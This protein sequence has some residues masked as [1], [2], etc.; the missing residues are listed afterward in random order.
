MRVGIGRGLALTLGAVAQAASSF[1][2]QIVLMR[3]LLPEDFGRF[4]V[5]LAGCSLV[6]TILSWRL[7]VLILRLAPDDLTSPA[8]L[9]Y[10]AGL[11]WETVAAACCTLV[12]L[13]LSGLMSLYALVLVATL[14]L[15][16]WG[17]QNI[18]FYE[19]SMAYGRITLVETG[20]QLFGHAMALA[21]VLAGAGPI[22]LYVRELAAII[23]R[24]T[25]FARLGVLVKPVLVCPNLGDLRQLW[26]ESRAIWFE[27]VLEGSF[28]RLVILTV[29]TLCG[30]HGAGIFA[31]SQRLA[32]L[33]HQF[34]SPVISRFAINLFNRTHSRQQRLVLLLRLSVVAAFVLVV[35]ILITLLWGTILVPWVFGPK[36]SEAGTTIQALAGLILLLPLFD[37]FRSYAYAQ[38][39]VAGIVAA[40]LG[41]IASFAIATSLAFLAGPVDVVVVGYTLST[42]YLVGFVILLTG[43]F[44][45]TSPAT[46]H[47]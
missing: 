2:T 15:A 45:K 46:P 40:R 3:L 36:W 38:N 28:A 9:R 22:A 8:A 6:Q 21:L 18:A 37:L 29:G 17:N 42:A 7:N 39:R 27:G 20:S 35:A 12:W 5:V 1:G 44:F 16:Q 13:A 4:A 14:T 47:S 24:I 41:Q 43:L 34:M 19:R 30:L 26:R 33:P 31:Q 10:Q 25:A 23:A 11:V 32:M